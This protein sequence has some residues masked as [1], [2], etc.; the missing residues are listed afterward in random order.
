MYRE[1]YAIK[2]EIDVKFIAGNL[3]SVKTEEK[4]GH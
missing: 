2:N 3:K 4:I 1:F